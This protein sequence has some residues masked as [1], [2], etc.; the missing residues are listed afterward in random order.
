MD[1]VWFPMVFTQ[2]S[3]VY[4]RRVSDGGAQRAVALAKGMVAWLLLRL[5]LKD[6]SFSRYHRW[7]QCCPERFILL[8][9]PKCS[10]KNKIASP[11][12]RLV[13]IVG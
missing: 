10:R 5:T 9:R 7:N 6:A 8:L 4:P 2:G 11:Q 13:W 12:P 3:R 1:S